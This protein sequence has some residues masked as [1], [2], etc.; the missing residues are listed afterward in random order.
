[1]TEISFSFLYIVKGYV[2]Q[3][4]QQQHIALRTDFTVPD[5]WYGK[6]KEG[7]PAKSDVKE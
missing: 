7:G 1:M 5:V 4:Q 2:R 6:V 3:Q